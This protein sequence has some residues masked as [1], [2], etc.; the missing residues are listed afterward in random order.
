MCYTAVTIGLILPH[1]LM[2]PKP[3]LL[4]AHMSIANGFVTAAQETSE[5]LGANALQIFLKSPRG[6][7]VSK[8]TPADAEKFRTYAAECGGLFL[9]VHSSYLINLAKPATAKGWDFDSLIEDLRNTA[10]L[11]GAGVVLHVGKSLS[12][13]YG[14]A[15]KHLVENLKRV[16]DLSQ[17]FSTE[18]I[19]ENTAQQGSE[20]GYRFEQLQSIDEKL[21]KPPR[22]SF[23]LD[24][25]HAFAAGYDLQTFKSVRAVFEEFDQRLGLSRLRVIHFND[26]KQP[27]GS[28]RDRHENLGLGHVGQEGL[29]AVAREA[30]ARD[31]PLILE[32]PEKTRTHKEDLELL[33]RWLAEAPPP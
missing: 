6:F 20:M 14:E 29:V 27:L 33:R 2:T 24:T 17:K 23:C 1:R 10:A 30:I 15:E 9:V 22:L 13:P 31:I 16:L 25:C 4:G 28:K 7:G 26:T 18:L 32:T 12:L 21:G 11:G 3:L 8:L 19:L 5:G